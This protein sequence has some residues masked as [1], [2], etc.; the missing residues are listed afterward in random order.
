VNG[1]G[2]RPEKETT[3]TANRAAVSKVSTAWAC[4]RQR[5]RTCGSVQAHGG[6][7][8]GNR[9]CAVTAFRE[10]EEPRMGA[11]RGGLL[12]VVEGNPSSTAHRHRTPACERRRAQPGATLPRGTP[13]CPWPGAPAAAASAVMPSTCCRFASVQGVAIS[14]TPIAGLY[15]MRK[16]TNRKPLG[17]AMSASSA[18][19]RPA[20]SVRCAPADLPAPAVEAGLEAQAPHHFARGFLGVGVADV[21][22]LA[23]A[24]SAADGVDDGAHHAVALALRLQSLGGTFWPSVI[25]AKSS[26]KTQAWRSTWLSGRCDCETCSGR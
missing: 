23:E 8:R 5:Q 25:S 12:V 4:C 17:V 22:R 13:A 19:K 24:S 21:Q 1:R 11:R 18:R 10:K 16:A 26:Q 3:S 7:R 14:F 9:Q 20:S 2:M 15:G 6:G